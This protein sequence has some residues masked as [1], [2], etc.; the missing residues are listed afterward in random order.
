MA[1]LFTPEV[2]GGDAQQ[3]VDSLPLANSPGGE[4]SHLGFYVLDAM[5]GGPPHQGPGLN[6]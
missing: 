3:Q 4:D 5:E 6:L 1:V 2:S